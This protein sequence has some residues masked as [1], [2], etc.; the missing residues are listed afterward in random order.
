MLSCICSAI[1]K[2]DN[3]LNFVSNDPEIHIITMQQFYQLY[4]DN[5]EQFQGSDDVPVIEYDVKLT[6]TDF[7]IR[8][9]K[10]AFKIR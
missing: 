2:F 9:A 8:K 1:E 10:S 3:F 7:L 4:Q 5:P 6:P